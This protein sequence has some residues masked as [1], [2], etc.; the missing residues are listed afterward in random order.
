VERFPGERP[1]R[2]RRAG[3]RGEAV[4]RASTHPTLAG[5]RSGRRGRRWRGRA[6]FTPPGARHA[7]GWSPPP[8]SGILPM[9]VSESWLPMRRSRT[10]LEQHFLA[11][12]TEFLRKE[13]G[14]D[15]QLDSE[16]FDVPDVLY[17]VGQRR[18]A[19][20]LSQFPS[21]YIIKH[22]NTP[23]RHPKED[24][25]VCAE[26][27]IFPFEPHRWVHEVL[28]KKTKRIR[29]YQSN[30][31]ATE[32]WMVM[33]AHTIKEKAWPMSMPSQVDRKELELYLM[34]YGAQLGR[35]FDRVL[36][37]Y[38]DGSVACLAGHDVTDVVNMSI[39]LENG[40]PV[41]VAH[42]LL[43]RFTVPKSGELPKTISVTG[44]DFKDCVI[45][46]NDPH[47]REL[48]PDIR[49]LDLSIKLLVGDRFAIFR[50]AGREEVLIPMKDHS[51]SLMCMAMV[52]R[53]DLNKV[54]WKVSLQG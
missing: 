6:G 49:P 18:I 37:I 28:S 42:H 51:G 5:R 3:W 1:E 9:K 36:Y 41:T 13:F 54:D 31:N 8:P 38:P 50:M 12:L 21:R 35:S 32:V 14:G 24:E 39:S 44:S 20:E 45:E 26:R 25:G 4:V 16:Q 10:D 52:L 53:G 48:N 47:W 40:Y 33:H 17:L 2:K 15:V 22:F 23:L 27:F 46:P 43:F 19:V 7:A 34:R 11:H 29:E 30:V